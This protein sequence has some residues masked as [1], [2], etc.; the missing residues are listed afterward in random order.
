MEQFFNPDKMFTY[1]KG[2]INGKGWK[3]S[4]KAL[5]FAR[6]LHAGQKRKGGDPYI[7]HPLTMACHAVSIGIDNDVI[8]AAI[9]L[10]DVVEDCNVKVDE[11]P[12]SDEVRQAVYLLSFRKP[13]NK[14]EVNTAKQMYYNAIRENPYATIAK[15]FD[16]C[17]NVSTMG[18]VFSREK[19]REYID[20]TRTFVVPLISHAKEMYPEY[21]S[22]L[23]DL[24]YH[25]YSL[26]Y[27]IEGMMRNE[28]AGQ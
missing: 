1:M 28:E 12:C 6:R 11:I 10:H 4:A 19:L 26:L 5:Q 8:I 16:R 14:D 23:F 22:Q 15:I 9:L 20:E 25:I 18:G 17:H 13:A 7:A 24:K 3:E 2:Y 27:S 21:Q